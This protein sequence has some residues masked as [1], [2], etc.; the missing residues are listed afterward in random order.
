MTN[1]DQKNSNKVTLKDIEDAIVSKTFTN[2][3]SGKQMVCELVLYNGFAVIGK[4]SV[5]DP[6]NHVQATGEKYAY[7]DAIEQCWPLFG[8]LLQESMY[9]SNMIADILKGAQGD[10]AAVHEQIKEQCRVGS[11]GDALA[12]PD[13]SQASVPIPEGAEIVSNH[14]GTMT[15]DQAMDEVRN[16]IPGVD[17]NHMEDFI[18]DMTIMAML[19][20][21]L[22]G[23]AER[24][25]DFLQKGIAT[26]HDEEE[27]KELAAKM[28]ITTITL[29]KPT[30]H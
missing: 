2:L 15:A 14:N 22:A 16:I 25:I 27:C 9:R 1:Q 23:G 20:Y 24:A 13:L 6:A 12:M 30:A 3:P 21:R 8:F 18:C 29:P 19:A 17:P 5:V 28:Y 11:V 10:L 26:M 4:S 7:E